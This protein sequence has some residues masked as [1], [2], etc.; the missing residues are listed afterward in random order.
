M[1]NRVVACVSSHLNIDP[2]IRR[3][4]ARLCQSSSPSF[5]SRSWK[6]SPLVSFSGPPAAFR[7]LAG[8][9]LLAVLTWSGKHSD[10]LRRTQWH[11]N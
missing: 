2:H 4:H 1:K 10:A 7:S 3:D 9:R 6:R 8:G 5:S 11:S